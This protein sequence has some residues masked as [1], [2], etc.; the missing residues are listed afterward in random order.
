MISKGEPAKIDGASA[1][2]S[3]IE[4]SDDEIGQA[5]NTSSY[6]EAAYDLG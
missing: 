6:S 1:K 5:D 2:S 3:Q 4:E